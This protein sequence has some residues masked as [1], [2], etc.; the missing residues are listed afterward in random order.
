MHIIL[1]KKLVENLQ[2]AYNRID[3]TIQR[4]DLSNAH[5]A[6]MTTISS[7]KL[8]HRKQVHAISDV[9]HISR[10][11][12]QRYIKR[13]NMLDDNIENNWVNICRVPQKDRISKDVKR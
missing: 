5:R 7:R 1:I 4:G 13:R 6:L 2:N 12:V 11:T 3:N 10:R 8:T 9:L